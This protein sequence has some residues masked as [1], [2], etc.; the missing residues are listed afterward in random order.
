MGKRKALRLIAVIAERKPDRLKFR[1]THILT[2]PGAPEAERLYFQASFPFD[3]G[4]PWRVVL[5]RI[6]DVYGNR[7]RRIWRSTQAD[8][9]RWYYE[10]KNGLQPVE[11]DEPGHWVLIAEL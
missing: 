3:D 4:D 6:S 10:L 2:P 8:C 7:T 9:E 11:V 5:D 1:Y